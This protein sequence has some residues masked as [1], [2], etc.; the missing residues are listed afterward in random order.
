LHRREK[1][2]PIAAQIDSL[3][4]ATQPL[5]AVDP[6]FN[7]SLFYV[8]RRVILPRFDPWF[9]ARY[10]LG[11]AANEPAAE[12]ATPWSPARPSPILRI[13]DY[14]HLKIVLFAVEPPDQN[15]P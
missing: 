1:V 2:R 13:E 8:R 4:R 3:V 12:W 5:Y 7:P 6:D 10:F 14:R 11:Q 15:P 9:A